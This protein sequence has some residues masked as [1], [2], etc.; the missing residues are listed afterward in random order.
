[1]FVLFSQV[2][3][4]FLKVHIFFQKMGGLKAHT[5]AVKQDVYSQ[6]LKV[7]QLS[8][9]FLKNAAILRTKRGQT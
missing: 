3:W 1:M 4:P 6:F 9:F 5:E 8:Q 7:Q 2:F